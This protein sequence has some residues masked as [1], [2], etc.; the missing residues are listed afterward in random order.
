LDSVTQLSYLGFE[1]SD[2][3]AWKHFSTQV[4][5]LGM[6]E[7]G[8]EVRLRLDSYAHRFLLTEGP[9]D[10]LNLVGW[11]VADADALAATAK[12]LSEAGTD[13][14]TASE[15]ECSARQVEAM[16]KCVDPSGIPLE[17]AYGLKKNEKPF[18]S[19]LVKSGFVAEEL[20]LGHLV[21]NAKSQKESL[22]FYCTLLGLGL[23]DYIRCEVYGFKVD[24]AFLHANGRH[25]SLAIGGDPRRRM[26]HFLVEAKT[27]DEVGLAYDRAIRNKVAISQTL[28]RHPN[29]QMFSFYAFTPSGFEFEFGWGGREIDRSTWTSTTYDRI[30]EWGHHPPELIGRRA[31]KTR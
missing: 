30:S 22:D 25:H 28:G 21:V 2:L 18:E 3:E 29:D 10:D 19:P 4:L 12:R 27:M 16:I 9:R 7:G 14:Q 5:G 1:V 13:V 26:H 31:P 24:I 23:S 8:N 15:E 20:G 6:L 17:I 11:Q